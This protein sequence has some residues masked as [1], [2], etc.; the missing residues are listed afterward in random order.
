MLDAAT[1]HLL[2]LFCELARA[3]DDEI[4]AKQ[5]FTYKNQTFTYYLN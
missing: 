3:L 4:L 1:K 2:Q 5:Q